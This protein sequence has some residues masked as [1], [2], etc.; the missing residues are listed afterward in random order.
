MFDPGSDLGFGRR[1]GAELVRDQPARL[2]P[3]P[4]QLSKE[5]FG[6]ARVPT[7]LNQDIQHIAIGVDRPPEPVLLALELDDDFVEMPFVRRS[8][9]L[10]T[11]PSSDLPAKARDLVPHDL[12]GN[13]DPT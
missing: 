7:R 12:V 6:C 13:P 1:V 8:G 2:A 4:E 11:D 10:A 9:A 3:A 5:A